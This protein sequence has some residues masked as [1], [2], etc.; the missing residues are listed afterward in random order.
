MVGN[1]KCNVIKETEVLASEAA[2]IY[3]K[4]SKKGAKEA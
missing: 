2:D 4:S 3:I 1:V